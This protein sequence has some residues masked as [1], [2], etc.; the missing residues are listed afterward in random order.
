[1]LIINT[2]AIKFSNLIPSVFIQSSLY[3]FGTLVMYV[4]ICLSLQ[5]TSLITVDRYLAVKSSITYPLQDYR[6]KYKRAMLILFSFDTFNLYIL[7]LLSEPLAG[8]DLYIT[9]GRI[10]F[11]TLQQ[12]ATCTIVLITGI[13]VRKTRNDS[14][15]ALRNA[16][17]TLHGVRAETLSFYRWIK[18]S[19]KDVLVLN[20]WSIIILVPMIAV[21][22]HLLFLSETTYYRINVI[23]FG[24]NSFFNVLIYSLTQSNIRSYLKTK[25]QRII[26]KARRTPVGVV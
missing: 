4:S 7:A 9:Y 1:M 22:M 2:F 6:D 21:N 26:Q 25:L 13:I 18:R 12:I 8:N 23:V 11:V 14:E 19:I 3:L 10:A 16:S 24:V 15:E 17:N 20:F 5:I